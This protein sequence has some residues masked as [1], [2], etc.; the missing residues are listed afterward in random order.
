MTGASLK[1]CARS[2]PVQLDKLF[3]EELIKPRAYTSLRVRC[4]G[5]IRSG[6]LICGVP[7]KQIHFQVSDLSN[8]LWTRIHRITDLRDQK[9]DH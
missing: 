5:R 7:F 1:N 4:F 9:T 3:R 2:K 6:F 8:P